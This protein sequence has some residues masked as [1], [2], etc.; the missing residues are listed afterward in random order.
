MFIESLSHLYLLSTFVSLLCHHPHCCPGL[1]HAQARPD[2]TRS[3]CRLL[4]AWR[5]NPWYGQIGITLLLVHDNSTFQFLPDLRLLS[6]WCVRCHRKSQG[7][8]W[9][10][11]HVCSHWPATLGTWRLQSWHS[12]LLYM[13]KEKPFSFVFILSSSTEVCVVLFS[14]LSGP[15]DHVKPVSTP[16]F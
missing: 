15:V 11:S 1:N 8:I 13:E 12:L 9:R 16:K 7:N 3:P 4:M 10:P 5:P 2:H 6:G 14:D